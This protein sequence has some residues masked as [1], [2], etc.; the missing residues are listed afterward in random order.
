MLRIRPCVRAQAATVLA[1]VCAA[2]PKFCR[3]SILSR[4]AALGGGFAVRQLYS[5]Q[6]EVLF[7]AARPVILNG[8]E[9]IVRRPDLADRAVWRGRMR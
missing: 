6:D 5:D 1:A 3:Q 4:F 2:C 9:D 8:I 7:D